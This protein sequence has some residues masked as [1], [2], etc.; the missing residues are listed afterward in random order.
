MT[1]IA[2]SR[3]GASVNGL[4]KPKAT[5]LIGKSVE[6][7]IVDESVTNPVRGLIT[8]ASKLARDM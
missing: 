3:I 8:D 4:C 1:M 7:R 2:A 6:N 5:R